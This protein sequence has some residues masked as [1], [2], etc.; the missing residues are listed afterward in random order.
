M[1]KTKNITKF[2]KIKNENLKTRHSIFLKNE[3]KWQ[4]NKIT[5]NY[6]ITENESLKTRQNNKT[7]KLHTFYQD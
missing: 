6:T 5:K 1:T 3:Y 4:K 2:T 7:T